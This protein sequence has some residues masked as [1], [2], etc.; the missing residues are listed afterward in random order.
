M[1]GM[2]LAETRPVV[3]DKVGPRCRGK[4]DGIALAF[5]LAVG[6]V[7]GAAAGCRGGGGPA[8]AVGPG[9]AGADRP[10]PSGDAEGRDA[11]GGPDAGATDGAARADARQ[12]VQPVG[13]CA[14]TSGR[15]L[16][17]RHLRS[18]DGTVREL[19]G[20][21]DSERRESCQFRR[22]T[23][24]TLRCLPER[25]SVLWIGEVA[26][27]ADAAC[28]LPLAPRQPAACP[29]RRYVEWRPSSSCSSNPATLAPF[30]DPLATG[31]AIHTRSGAGCA[32]TPAD[33]PY[34]AIGPAVPPTAFVEAT[35]A[36]STSARITTTAL[37]A[38]DGAR[39]PCALPGTPGPA[40]VGLDLAPGLFIDGER[41]EECSPG[42]AG[43]GKVRCLPHIPQWRQLGHADPGCTTPAVGL[44]AS[45]ARPAYAVEPNPLG[46]STCPASSNAWKVR[47]LGPPLADAY[48]FAQTMSS[49]PTFPVCSRLE[50]NPQLTFYPLAEELP[51]ASFAELELTSTGTGRLRPL[52]YQAPGGARLFLGRFEDTSRGEECTAAFAGDGRLRCLPANA[53]YRIAA[54]FSDAACLQ[55]VRVAV[56]VAPCPVA[57][58]RA[59]VADES[60]AC[61]RQVRLYAA[62]ARERRPL[63]YRATDGGC[64]AWNP[65][66]SFVAIGDELPPAAFAALEATTE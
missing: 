16:R 2:T 52:A 63:F 51:A 37:V 44:A 35:G 32:A 46:P 31:A 17:A 19:V 10:P 28:A 43:D 58:E 57:P 7:G 11:A 30:G 50:T 8:T 53:A 33:G 54:A 3:N 20:W 5:V 47:R 61:P 29:P 36:P 4:G 26:H 56:L 13:S 1:T 9:D 18:D 39:E 12:P 41:G 34:A 64:S 49:A 42:R 59:L 15:R 60:A 40:A 48:G 66:V 25:E 65:Q 55:P 45:C 38:G 24:G 14:A 27:Y 62:G 22:A 21:W 23:D 6:L